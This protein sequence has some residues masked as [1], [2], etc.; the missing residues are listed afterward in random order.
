MNDK[1]SLLSNR[2]NLDTTDT[3][4]CGYGWENDISSI[5]LVSK[6]QLEVFI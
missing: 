5:P 3:G 1:I 4:G 2:S 6:S